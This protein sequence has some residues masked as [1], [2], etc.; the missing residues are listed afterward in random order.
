MSMYLY[1]LNMVLTFAVFCGVVMRLKELRHPVPTTPCIAQ[2]LV[3]A[4]VY[5]GIA[6]GMLGIFFHNLGRPGFVSPWYV[7]ILRASLVGLFF[8]E[9]R[10]P[11]ARTRGYDFRPPATDR[12]S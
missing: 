10:N 8:T 1:M 5:I 12:V 4:C 2:W 6:I 9:R 11:S 3:M 7:L